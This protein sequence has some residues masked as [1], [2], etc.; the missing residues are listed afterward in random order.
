MRIL[1]VLLILFLNVI[2][3]TAQTDKPKRSELIYGM[4][5]IIAAEKFC[6][7]EYDVQAISD[8]LAHN[9]PPTDLTF[10]DDLRREAAAIS[11]NVKQKMNSDSA[12]TM[13]CTVQIRAA[14]NLGF[15][16]RDT[17]EG[18]SQSSL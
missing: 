12:K 15:I 11:E 4:A 18:Q 17:N 6:N 13:Y 1:E 14:Y 3:A 16:K 5:N 9:V 2:Q 8:Y 10:G 7:V